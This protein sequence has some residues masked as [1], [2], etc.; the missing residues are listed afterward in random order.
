MS[1]NKK[2]QKNCRIVDFAVPADHRIKPKESEKR[3]KYKN[4]ARELDKLGNMK[5][6][7]IPIVIGAFGII[8]KG[9][10]KGLEDL[11]ISRYHPD[12]SII[13]VYQ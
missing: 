5:V 3:D 10:V 12:Y 11:E 7:V 1:A 6:T 8:L 4:L 9:L 13:V 2:T